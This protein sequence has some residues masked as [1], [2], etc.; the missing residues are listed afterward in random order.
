MPVSHSGPGI[1]WDFVVRP[2]YSVSGVNIVKERRIVYK[3]S[4]GDVG[5]RD[6]LTSIAH[7]IYKWYDFPLLYRDRPTY[8][9]VM[10]ARRDSNAT[11][12]LA[13][14][15]CVSANISDC[16]TPDEWKYLD[17]L[18]KH[19]NGPLYPGM[20]VN[21][22]GK[23]V[24]VLPHIFYNVPQARA[25]AAKFRVVQTQADLVVKDEDY[26]R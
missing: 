18:N 12:R 21:Q 5:A 24:V 4:R 2:H 14:V 15:D 17:N 22:E 23:T 7:N 8:S 25:I 19:V 26:E 9:D 6:Y 1:S 13:F 16:A 11:R 20:K 10:A 3:R